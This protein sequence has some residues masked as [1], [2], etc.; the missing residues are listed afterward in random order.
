MSRAHWL[1]TYVTWGAAHERDAQL[2]YWCRFNIYSYNSIW[3]AEPSVDGKTCQQIIQYK[4]RT[5]SRDNIKILDKLGRRGEYE[6]WHQWEAIRSQCAD[7]KHL[8]G[9]LQEMTYM[10]P[11][12]FTATLSGNCPQPLALPLPGHSTTDV[13]M[14][15]PWPL[16]PQVESCE[17]GNG[18]QTYD[19]GSKTACAKADC[20]AI[21]RLNDRDIFHVNLV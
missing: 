8:E 2:V 13:Q 21:T 18:S 19:A 6:N 1:F 9:K 10:V 15:C 11:I 20:D 17:S 3:A 7:M 5:F 14:F 12:A 4:E 16:K